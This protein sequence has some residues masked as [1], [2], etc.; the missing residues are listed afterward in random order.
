MKTIELG[1]CVKDVITGFE[2]IA[3]SR[4]EYLTGC[5]QIGVTPIIKDGKVQNTEYFDTSRLEYV[6]EGITLPIDNPGGPNRDAPNR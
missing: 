5:E 4:V 3:T 1:N 2:G 6:H